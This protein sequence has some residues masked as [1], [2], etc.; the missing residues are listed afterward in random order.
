[1]DGIYD[2]AE[3]HKL[4]AG[5]TSPVELAAELKNRGYD[6]ILIN[7]PEVD[8][9]LWK[10]SE[11]YPILQNT[12]FLDT[13]GE[14]VFVRNGIYVYRF[15]P[16]G[17]QL[18]PAEN[19]IKNAGFETLESEN[20][21][22]EWI[23]EGSVEDSQNAYQGNHSLFINAPASPKGNGYV[24]QRVPVEE[25]K[26]YTLGYWINTDQQATFLM[27][28]R[29]LDDQGNLISNE[30]DWKSITPG[31]NWYSLHSQA[32]AGAQFA[33]VFASLGGA[34]N[35]WVDNICLAEGQRCPDMP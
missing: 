11:P 33:N 34:E 29:W 19:L 31:W 3:A 22:N 26:L 27:Q 2:V 9:R 4:F 35:A 18:P 7:Q 6:Y 14:L 5:A 24:Y 17:V 23:E 10:Y 8:F 30:E 25:G 32:P 12:K 20:D 15:V 16:N 21:F 28:I 1:V 13:Y